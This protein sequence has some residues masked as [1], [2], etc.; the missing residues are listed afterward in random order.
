MAFEEIK[1]PLI[2]VVIPAY[3]AAHYLNRALESVFS[4]SQLPQE[5]IVIDDGSTDDTA[6]IV[7]S[8]GSRIIYQHQS[9]QGA[10]VARNSGIAIAKNEM[11]A[12][13]D[14]DDYWPK[15]K[16]ERQMK[17]LQENP[18]ADLVWGMVKIE[19]AHENLERFISLEK[20]P[21]DVAPIV[22]LGAAL[23]RRQAFEKVGLFDKKFDPSEDWDWYNR[24]QEKK[25]NILRDDAIGLYYYRHDN[26]LTNDIHKLAQ[27]HLY[28]LKKTLNRRR[29]ISTH[30]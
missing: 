15:D 3:N 19:Y 23:F 29:Q 17:L 18:A 25:L 12:F 11:I 10:S 9:N 7:K 16:L 27:S 22:C 5:I 30:G 1:M 28:F 26:N 2:S 20:A 21:D 13:L 8:F 4:Q 24:A 6:T 14:A